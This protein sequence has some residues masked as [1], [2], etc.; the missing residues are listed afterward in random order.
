MPAYN[1]L[2]NECKMDADAFVPYDTF[3]NHADEE[4]A[5]TCPVC[6]KKSAFYSL[7][8][9][10]ENLK[11]VYND[12]LNFYESGTQEKWMRGLGSLGKR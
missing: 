11:P 8:H 6:G 4:H 9:L 7:S 2:C 1:I 3:C 10:K 5:I 12:V